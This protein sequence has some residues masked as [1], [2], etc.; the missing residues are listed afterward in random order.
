MAAKYGSS[1]FQSSET[2][3][4]IKRNDPRGLALYRRHYSC[5]MGERHNSTGIKP[6]DRESFVSL[7]VPLVLLKAD[8]EDALF[9]WLRRGR[10]MDGQGFDSICCTVFRNESPARSSDLILAAEQMALLKWPDTP[11]FFTYIA[12]S[13]IRSVNPGYCFKVAGWRRC[14][15]TSGGL[16]VL[17][18]V[19]RESL[20][21]PNECKP[22]NSH[23]L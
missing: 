11:R 1:L 5:G 9:V 22:C 14:G 2:W 21:Y 18:K 16:L 19:L 17:E 6:E 3:F 15:K 7:G 12:A 20:P 4:P 13:R 8:G 10:D 23:A